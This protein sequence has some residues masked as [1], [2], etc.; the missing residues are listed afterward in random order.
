MLRWTSIVCAVMLV[1][2]L[3][4]GGAAHAAEQ[5]SCIPA[6]AEATIHFDGDRDQ[7]SSQNGEDVAHHHSCN[8]HQIAAAG[9]S[10]GLMVL[11]G[12]DTFG[13]R[14]DRYVLGQGP[15]EQLRPP[16]A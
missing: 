8:G 10:A 13:R 16:I 11:A 4:T 5:F 14:I 12:R 1:L 15:S 2:M 6:G 9:D 7:Q 3:W